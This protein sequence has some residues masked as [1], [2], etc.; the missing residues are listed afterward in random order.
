MIT[1]AT[2]QLAV[3]SSNAPAPPAST[4][5]STPPAGSGCRNGSCPTMPK[6]S[7]PPSPTP[8]PR[9]VS[10][11][12]IP[13]PTAPTATA[14]PNGSTRPPRNGWPSN[15]QQPRSPNS[16]TNW[17]CS[18]SPTT[19]NV[20][21]D[22]LT[23]SSPPTCGSPRPSPAPQPATRSNHQRPPQ[24][25]AQR[26]MPR[27]SLPDQPRQHLQRPTRPHRDHRHRR[28]R[29]HQRAPHPPTHPQPRNHLPTPLQPTRQTY[30][31]R[32]GSPA[33]P[34]RDAPRQD[35]ALE[36]DICSI[37]GWRA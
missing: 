34:V 30:H 28:S 31:H 4:L 26:S 13:A 8:S 36:R 27:R 23:A 5:S 2:R 25:R 35:I 29:L 16:S 33:T 20:H 32:E 1:A 15:H 11:P 10:L 14:K 7:L 18:A 22:H 24:H 17:T 3:P 37:F 19:R 6:P 12:A 21:T 9:S